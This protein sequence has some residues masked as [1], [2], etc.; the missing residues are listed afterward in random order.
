MIIWELFLNSINTHHK[1]QRKYKRRLSPNWCTL[2]DINEETRECFIIGLASRFWLILFNA[3]GC[4]TIPPS[5]INS[6]LHKCLDVQPFKAEAKVIWI[7]LISPL[8][9]EIGKKL[10]LTWK[11]RLFWEYILLLWFRLGVGYPNNL[12]TKGYLSVCY[13]L[14]WA[15]ILLPIFYGL[16]SSLWQK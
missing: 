9:F 10:E 13:F 2:F 5:N 1:V 7:N 14:N 16:N 12:A 11:Q 8:E 15:K 4:H 6:F 3:F